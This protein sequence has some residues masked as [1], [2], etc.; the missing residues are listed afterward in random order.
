VRPDISMERRD[1]ANL[2]CCALDTKGQYLYCHFVSG[3][4]STTCV[5]CKMH[6]RTTEH[7]TKH[8]HRNSKARPRFLLTLFSALLKVVYALAFCIR[9]KIFVTFYLNCDLFLVL[10]SLCVVKY[11]VME[12][13]ICAGDCLLLLTCLSF[14]ILCKTTLCAMFII[15][16]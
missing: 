14:L 1:E 7:T 5:D 9:I 16:K 6:V 2:C 12:R 8:G 3:A 11:N 15:N 4:L 10:V 13:I